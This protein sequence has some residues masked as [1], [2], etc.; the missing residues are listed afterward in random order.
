MAA[1][2]RI[3]ESSED[4]LETI[5]I[6]SEEQEGVRSVDI[7]REM[8]LSKPSVSR[9]I[10]ILK[11]QGYIHVAEHGHILL[12]GKGQEQAERVY[13]RHRVLTDFLMALGVDSET[14]DDDACRMEHVI[15]E[16]SFAKIKEHTQK[17][18][19][20]KEK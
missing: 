20:P 13:E 14:A 9:A 16:S 19:Q 18:L 7:A 12:T 17:T 15:S 5:L 2:K 4:Y 6:L 1:K 10:G 8:D 11:D 3:R